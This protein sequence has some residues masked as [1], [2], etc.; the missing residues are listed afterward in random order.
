MV[1]V[2]T[3]GSMRYRRSSYRYTMIVRAGPMGPFDDL[4][5]GDR[6]RPLVQAGWRPDAD[7]YETTSTIE[8]VVDLAGVGEDDFEVQ[9]FE[10]AL[11]VDGRRQLPACE[12]GARYQVAS[13]RQ[14]P[15]R[16]ELPVPT[17][18]DSERV[19]ARYE[20]GLLWITLPKRAGIR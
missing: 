8:I 10:D 9:L 6:A 18:V 1:S 5:Q 12:E 7:V 15:F 2:R 3:W 16:L 4:W 14:G 19:E 13:I 11:V 17:P 20:R